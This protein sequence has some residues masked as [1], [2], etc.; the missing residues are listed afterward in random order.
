VVRLT[1]RLQF[2]APNATVVDQGATV[3]AAAAVPDPGVREAIEAGADFEEIRTLLTASP[4]EY[5]VVQY[6]GRGEPTVRA[7]RGITS[8]YEVFTV[9]GSNGDVVVTDAFRNAV[10]ALDPADRTV[11]RDTVADH[12]LFRTTPTGAYV[13]EVDRLGHGETLEW[14]LGT[15][16]AT[17]EQVERIR[18]A[19]E[20]G[21]AAAVDHL[22]AEFARLGSLDDAATML[23]GGVDS[24][25]LH[26]YRPAGAP[27]V[28]GGFDS[29]E[30]RTEFDYAR[31]ARD[32]LDADHE[33]EL[34]SESE[35]RERLEDTIEAV[36]MPPQMIQ[37]PVR[38][39]VFRGGDRERYLS[40][41]RSDSLFGMGA[42]DARLVWLTRHLRHL[43]TVVGTQETHGRI[44]R[45][46]SRAPDD[47][48]GWATGVSQ[49]LALSDVATMVDDDRIERRQRNRFRYA[50]ERVAV[51]CDGDQFGEQMHWGHWIEFFCEGAV[52]IEQ[53]LASARGT[54]MVV[55]FSWSSVAELAAA[56]PSPERYLRR[57]TTKHV[58]KRLLDRRVPEYDTDK[59]KGNGHL[60][61]RRYLTS[62][63]LRP[64]LDEYEI[65]AFAAHDSYE[66]AIDDARGLGWVLLSYAVW[67]D[68]VL[69]R[70]VDPIPTSRTV[71]VAPDRGVEAS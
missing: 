19:G 69:E 36:A 48:Y 63:P 62:G 45:Q 30:V 43:P 22:D 47:H 42:D 4:G 61:E 35:F 56:V 68:R 46:L 50:R 64:A 70:E 59:P 3:W 18:T 60:P 28:S 49:Y 44:A 51:D 66:A 29:P 6:D 53:Q 38:D 10:A 1:V 14:D 55:P 16:E 32:V 17:T 13:D 37:M 58:P 7:H 11:S 23:S 65:P 24:T 21:P 57:L 15:G 71:E 27:S 12:L 67:R 26:S 52:S 34:A 33:F 9:R 8:T 20:M 39:A 31:H 41:M 40:G 2:S 5:T 54:T 25:L